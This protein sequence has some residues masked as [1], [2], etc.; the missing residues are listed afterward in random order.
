MSEFPV[1]E[2][3]ENR[4]VG[5]IHLGGDGVGVRMWWSSALD[6]VLAIA[7]AARSVSVVSLHDLALG[8]LASRSL[9]LVAPS[10]G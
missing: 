8:A 10:T 9:S 2:C 1:E 3:A 5:N 7:H 4:D 6:F